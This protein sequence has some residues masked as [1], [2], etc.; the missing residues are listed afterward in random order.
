M[1]TDIVRTY[2]DIH[3]WV[4]IISGL[5]LFIAFYAGAITMFETPL[6]RWAS[7]PSRL[8]PPPA[9]ENTPRLIEAA[10]AAYP[11][12]AKSYE[13][14]LA[15]GPENPARM[16]WSTGNRRTPGP[17]FYASLNRDGSLQVVQQGPSEVA[18]L[19]D[20][21]HQQVGLPFDPEIAMPVMGAVAL[22]Y[23]IALISGVICLLPSL[24]K[25]LFALRIGM[26]VKRM[27]LD[28][29]NVLGLF[30]LPFHIVMALTAVVF[31]FHDQFY[32]AQ[33]AVRGIGRVQ[34]ERRA[35]PGHVQPGGTPLPPAEIAGEVARQMPGFTLQTIRYQQSETA[36]AS[37]R[38]SGA[39]PRFGMRGPT[40]TFGE[41][42]PLTGK[43][44]EEDYLPGRQSGWFATVTSFFALH[45]GSFGGAPVRWAY[46]ILG[47]AGAFL[48]YSGNLLWIE[49]RRKKERKAGA[50]EQTRATKLLGALTIGVPL[51]CIAG[52][53]VTI[54]ASKWLP[55]G[56]EDMAAWHSRIYYGVF[57]AVVAWAFA[58][59]AARGGHELL[60]V[61]ALA[62]ALIP[63]A[64]C[65]AWVS[66]G[67]GWSHGDTTLLVDM[68]A[69]AGALALFLMARAAKRRAIDGPRD[70]IWSITRPQPATK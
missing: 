4:G 42:D 15:T 43:I 54:A 40:F 56:L 31:A 55:L 41:V 20:V 62:T 5:T 58:R 61:A 10:L 3:S 27:W 28:L 24:T 12:A 64:T 60:R 68:V 37:I 32:D 69:A 8:A 7:P 36:G 9:L 67:W 45:F 53:S 21:L 59:G 70:S 57:L 16:S 35:P 30:S 33:G 51:G 39:D 48:F 63:A 6:Q 29:H 46:F 25:D 26:N 47:L 14:H 50:V 11:Q 22:L 65:L 38:I 44:T 34:E 13:I 19:I 66:P 18:G 2:K 1:R 49:S 52:I 23:A 17:T